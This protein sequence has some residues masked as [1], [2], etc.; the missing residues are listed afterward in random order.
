MKTSTRSHNMAKR[1]QRILQHAR[2]V[3]GTTG[4]AG[5]NLRSLAEAAGVTVPTIYNLV[6]N[7]RQILIELQAELM[8]ELER[9]LDERRDSSALEMAEAIVMESTRMFATGDD[10]FRAALLAQEQLEQSDEGLPVT[11][12]RHLMRRSERLPERA[13]E[14][15]IEDGQL[16]GA[17]PPSTL[18]GQMF[19]SYR[20]ACRDWAYRK[21]GIEQFKAQA[22]LG[23]YVTLAADATDAFHA[24]LLKKIHE[25]T[26]RTLTRHEDPQA[27]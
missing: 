4:Y 22:L 7:K 6:G 26:P 17:I 8:G 1:R 20:I 2:A 3:V 14:R 12:P 5:L 16:H 23:V 18:A 11:L 13:C 25:V 9:K 10:S 19:R 21:I 24:E 15:G 27:A